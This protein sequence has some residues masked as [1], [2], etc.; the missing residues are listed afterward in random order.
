MYFK[1]LKTGH[2]VPV[3]PL[4][5]TFCAIVYV[6][7]IKKSQIARFCSDNPKYYIE[8]WLLIPHNSLTWSPGQIA[9]AGYSNL[10][11]IALAYEKGSF[12]STRVERLKKVITSASSRKTPPDLIWKFRVK[13]VPGVGEVI[14]IV[15][16]TPSAFLAF[17]QDQAVQVDL[18]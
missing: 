1:N 10:K 14:S 17:K 16:G 5:R 18:F 3:G 12:K 6:T 9:E 4:G 13:E 7:D 8:Q 15:Y 11:E 2:Y